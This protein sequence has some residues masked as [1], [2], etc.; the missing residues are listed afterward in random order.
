MTD[1]PPYDV[2]AIALILENQMVI[3][4][5]LAYTESLLLNYSQRRA[6]LEQIGKTDFALMSPHFTK[7]NPTR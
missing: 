6:L 7:G 5:T 2:Q 3:M 4:R 1:H